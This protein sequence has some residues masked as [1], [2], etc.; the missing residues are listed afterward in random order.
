MSF[1]NVF[2]AKRHIF[3][4]SNKIESLVTKHLYL[5]KKIELWTEK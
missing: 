4:F 1:L 5:G 3:F 2:E